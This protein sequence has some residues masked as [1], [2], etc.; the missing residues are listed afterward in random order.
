MRTTPDDSGLKN[1]WSTR[2]EARVILI[3]G[4]VGMVVGVAIMAS[5]SVA[6]GAGVFTLALVIAAFGAVA[7]RAKKAKL[8]AAGLEVDLSDRPHGLTF[9]QAAAS[10]TDSSLETMIP[11][12][13]EDVDV[14]TAVVTLSAKYDGKNLTEPDLQW[15]RQELNVS[16][17]AAKRPND[18]TWRGGGR[19][20][21]LRLGTGTE[22][23][24]AG[25]GPDIQELI[26]RFEKGP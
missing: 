14:S 10:A 24:V 6:I 1:F 11:L 20:S 22:L 19:I 13:A 18:S 7:D 9:V 15:I 2:P 17:F 25:D 5:S 12:L 8:T 21:T 26:R 4:F 16:V 23:A 3:V